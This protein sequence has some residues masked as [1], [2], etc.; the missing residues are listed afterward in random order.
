MRVWYVCVYV[1]SCDWNNIV[2]SQIIEMI[3]LGR[4]ANPEGVEYVF[5]V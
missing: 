2:Y 3:P 4:I 1:C 5:I